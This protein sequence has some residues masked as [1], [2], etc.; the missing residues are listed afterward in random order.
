MAEWIYFIHPPRDDLADTMTTRGGW[1]AMVLLALWLGTAG[2]EFVGRPE[3]VC[4]NVEESTCQRLAAGLL[5]EARRDEPGKRV[6][7]L[8][9]NGPGGTYDMLFSDGTGKAVV[10][11]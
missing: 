8:T 3:V 4:R 10:G 5:E 11:H 1:A 9:I 6:V 2:C 7:K